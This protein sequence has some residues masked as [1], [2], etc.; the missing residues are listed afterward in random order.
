M[1]K[2]IF[3]LIPVPGQISVKIDLSKALEGSQTFIITEDNI[4]MPKNIKLLDVVPPSIELTLAA[5]I[6]RQ[7][8]VKPQLVGKLPDGLILD[9]LE[10]KPEKVM[11]LVPSNDEKVRVESVMT[12][13]IYLEGIRS[14][15][16]IFCK[17]IAPPSVQPVDKRWPD[18]E[19]KIT[20]TSPEKREAGYR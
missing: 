6:R 1:K 9:S 10:V 18:V 16:K 19:V 7:A 12:T 2:S 5:I 8:T 13:P 4:R 11:I 3:Y 17:I 20:V 15:L 14:D